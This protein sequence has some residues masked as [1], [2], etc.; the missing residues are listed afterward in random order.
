M[1]SLG[2]T[3][4]PF[5]SKFAFNSLNCFSKACNWEVEAF[6]YLSCKLSRLP[7]LLAKKSLTKLSIPVPILVDGR[8]QGLFG[9]NLSVPSVAWITDVTLAYSF[10]VESVYTPFLLSRII[11]C[12]SV[13]FL[14]IIVCVLV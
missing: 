6:G 12:V 4:R 9:S 14:F 5:L 3:V 8:I 2:T 13:L 11:S 10:P 7:S 1:I